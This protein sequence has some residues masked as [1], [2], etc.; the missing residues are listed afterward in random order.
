MT[1]NKNL[2]LVFVVIWWLIIFR[3]LKNGLFHLLQL[4]H[5]K[6]VLF[7]LIFRS[8][9]SSQFIYIC[10]SHTSPLCFIENKLF[11][12]VRINRNRIG[13]K[14]S[15]IKEILLKNVS[16]LTFRIC[17]WDNSEIDRWKCIIMVYFCW[18]SMI[19]HY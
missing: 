7:K 14:S 17:W 5:W 10:K 11:L 15:F 9:Y 8:I 2:A 3:Y 1:S 4:N 16:I 19:F 12:N 6:C 18:R 13:H